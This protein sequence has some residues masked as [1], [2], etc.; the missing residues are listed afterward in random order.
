MYQLFII[1]W[2]LNFR[3]LFVNSIKPTIQP[4]ISRNRISNESV[5]KIMHARSTLNTGKSL[6]H[7]GMNARAV[8]RSR[9]QSIWRPPC[10]VLA[11][12]YCLQTHT[13]FK[14]F[15]TFTVTPW[16]ITHY[17]QIEYFHSNHLL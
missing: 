13:T 14:R 10:V 1:I 16:C 5:L 17:G 12:N 15:I 11:F 9:A 3:K 7:C 4:L 2:Y 8:R 6:N